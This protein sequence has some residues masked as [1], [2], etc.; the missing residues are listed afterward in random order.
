[1]LATNTPARRRTYVSA[2]AAAWLLAG[3]LCAWAFPPAPSHI[4]YGMVR[5]KYGTPIMNSQAQVVLKTTS[6]TTLATSILPG[7]AIGVNY[8]IRVPMDAAF[9]SDIYRTNAL[10]AGVPYSMVVVV[11]GT[12][13]IPIEML[14]ANL[15]LGQPAGM[16]HVDLTLGTDSNHNGIPDEWEKAFLSSTGSSLSLSNL[17][18]STDVL[19][20]GRSLLQEFLL[21]TYPFDPGDTFAARILGFTNGAPA[22]EFPTMTGRSYTVLGSPDLQSWSPLGFQLVSDGP[23]GIVRSNYFAPTITT[24]DVQVVPP[25]TV[26][27]VQFYKVQLQ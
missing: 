7:L 27:A 3:S 25:P 24:L 19:G 15:Q 6:G 8:E 2:F 12:T 14:T 10:Q 22:L 4:V 18:A 21:G 5:D 23:D 17:T 9:T 26:R 11:N 1:M 20:D 13:N 16:T